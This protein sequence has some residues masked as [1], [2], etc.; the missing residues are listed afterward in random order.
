M[1]LDGFDYKGK[2]KIVN[3]DKPVEKKILSLKW[4]I[5]LKWED[6][7]VG[8]NRLEQNLRYMNEEMILLAP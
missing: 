1:R 6:Q 2:G 3:W 7:A 5:V 8:T 4:R